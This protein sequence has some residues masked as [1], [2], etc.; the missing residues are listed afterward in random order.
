VTDTAVRLGTLGLSPADLDAII[1]THEH[2]DH[3]G[4]AAR[5]ARKFQI[6]VYLTHGTLAALNGDRASMPAV[7]V[8]DAHDPFSVGDIEVL[9]FP[10]P[11]DA[12]EPAQFV[13]GDGN[14]R[15]GVLT[16]TG[17]STAH[18]V[19]ML[20]GVAAL[21][22]ECNHDRVMLERGPYPPSLKSRV[23]GRFGHL[24]NGAAAELLRNLDSSRLQHLIA[25]HLSQKNNTPEL[26]RAALAGAIGCDQEWVGVAT[27]EAGFH[28]RELR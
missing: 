9:P 14:C 27:Q 18:I 16:D 4:G 21:V 5:L 23:G 3:A 8:I 17:S 7:N 10:V 12:R 25:A 11:H 26:A 2:D 28:W 20:S 15:L 13:F 22:L 1:V 6:P 24:E 19:S